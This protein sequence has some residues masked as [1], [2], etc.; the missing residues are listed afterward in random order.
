MPSGGELYFI[1]TNVFV[2]AAAE[3]SARGSELDEVQIG[4]Q[5]V[6]Q[7]L[8]A[9]RLRGVTSLTVLREI[10]YLLARWA[11][12]RQAPSRGKLQPSSPQI[13]ALRLWALRLWE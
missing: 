2:Y 9:G 12:Q 13:V 8:R 4:S 6:I 3:S 10:L 11:R 7:D 1:D 5:R